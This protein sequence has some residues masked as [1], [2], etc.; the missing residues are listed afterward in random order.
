MVTVSK[1]EQKCFA[2]PI[3]DSSNNVVYLIGICVCAYYWMQTGVWFGWEALVSN[4]WAANAT[5]P[6]NT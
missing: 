4:A 1:S 3:L 2:A 6:T 5:S